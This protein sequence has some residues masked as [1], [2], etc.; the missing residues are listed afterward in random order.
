[1]LDVLGFA[2]VA[3]FAVSGAISAGRKRLDVLAV[4]LIAVITALGG[5]TLRDVVLGVRPVIWVGDT[6]YLWV[7]IGAAI[8]T[9]LWQ[10]WVARIEP[11]LVYADAGGLAL[12]SVLATERSLIAGAPAVVAVLMGVVTSITGGILRDIL[13]GDPPLVMRGEVY[14][15]CAVLGSLTYLGLRALDVPVEPSLL[16]G[17]TVALTSR[18]FAIH[19]RLSLPLFTW[20]DDPRMRR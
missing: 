13:C 3:V 15:T 8:A 9:M 10:R 6:T 7:A 16:L 1:M 17:A 2:G 19:M 5:G 18:L 12:F 14:A 20:N 4:V 11:A